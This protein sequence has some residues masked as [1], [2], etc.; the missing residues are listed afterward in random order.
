VEHGFIPFVTARP[1]H[2]L[3]AAALALVGLAIPAQAAPAR[4]NCPA[5]TTQ[6]WVDAV[7]DEG[8]VILRSGGPTH[9]AGLQLPETAAARAAALAFL[10]ARR[11]QAVLVHAAPAPDRWNRRSARLVLVDGPGRLDVAHALLESGLAMVDPAT[12]EGG[13]VPERVSIEATARER[14]LGLWAEDRYKPVPVA[15]TGRLRERIGQFTLVEGRIRSVGERRQQTYL[16]F[17]ADWASDFTIIIPKRIWTLLQERGLGA[18]I[19]TGRR[20]RARGILEDRQ[21][22]ALTVTAGEAIEILEE[23]PRR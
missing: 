3:L 13:C 23:R 2:R 7:T 18:A 14:G 5:A 6:D 21:G 11:A 17:G 19:L 16:N 22:P 15:E 8:D 10:R 12:G 1:M 4:P 20:I 9:L